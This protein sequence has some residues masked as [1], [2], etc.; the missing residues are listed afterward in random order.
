MKMWSRDVHLVKTEKECVPAGSDKLGRDALLMDV[1]ILDCANPNDV[2]VGDST[3]S[4]GGICA[5]VAEA[6]DVDPTE[7][8]HQLQLLALKDKLKA[9][10]LLEKEAVEGFGATSGLVG[11]KCNPSTS[12]GY[13]DV[14]VLNP[15]QNSNHVCVEDSSSSLGVTCV[16]IGSDIDTY[17]NNR[18][19]HRHLTECM[20]QHGT[21]LV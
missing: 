7:S 15:C 10:H 12:K 11:E 6:V 2:C 19:T 21:Q 3:S 14:R 20:Y 17:G 1:E 9:K 16:E 13:I 18:G 4:L 5:R 8:T